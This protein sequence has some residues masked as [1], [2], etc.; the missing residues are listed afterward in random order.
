ML[1][2]RVALGVL[3]LPCAQHQIHE[4]QILARGSHGWGTGRQRA[5][6]GRGRMTARS[7]EAGDAGKDEI[8]GDGQARSRRRQ[9]LSRL[10]VAGRPWPNDAVIKRTP[11]PEWPSVGPAPRPEVAGLTGPKSASRL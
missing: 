11:Q 3:L 4:H 9:A 2:M 10:G 7:V 8:D 1:L 5:H 6:R